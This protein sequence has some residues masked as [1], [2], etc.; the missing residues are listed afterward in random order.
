MPSC[1]KKNIHTVS[2]KNYQYIFLGHTYDNRNGKQEVDNRILNIDFNNYDLILLGG[3]I[4]SNTTLEY[5][6]LYYVDSIF[7]IK[8]DKTL[9]ALGNHDYA[10]PDWVKDFSSKPRY[11][12]FNVN[13]ISFL[14]LDTQDSACS[15]INDQLM[16]IQNIADTILHSS[17]LII[18]HHKLIWLRDNTDLSDYSYISNGPFGDCSYCIN[19][20]NFYSDIY[21][22]LR[23][24]QQKGIQVIMIGGDIGIYAKEFEYKTPDGIYFLA[25]GLKA[26]DTADQV[27]IIQHNT[28]IN[29]LEWQYMKLND[30]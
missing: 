12:A 19:K 21:P 25:S 7:N 18:I 26:G 27:L 22:L 17:H 30:F 20:N 1:K 15:I 10:N 9:W 28:N 23:S 6:T 13:N 5:S 2:E 11:Y 14:V 29:S 24:I 4:T 16:L 8:S 3:D